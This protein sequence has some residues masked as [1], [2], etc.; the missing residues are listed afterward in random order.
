VAHGYGL[1]AAV[2]PAPY[3]AFVSLLLFAGVFA[4]GAWL[5]TWFCVHR[6]DE[7]SWPLFI[8]PIVGVAA[9]A[10]VLYPLT[11]FGAIGPRTLS[12]LAVLL[13][14]LGAWAF[15]RTLMGIWREL[16]PRLS[17]VRGTIFLW[18]AAPYWMLALLALAALSPST[19]ADSLHYHLGVALNFLQGDG[20][21]P[22]TPEW[23]HS[24]LSGSGEALIAL[25]LSIGAEQFASLLQ[26]SGVFC[27]CGLLLGLGPTRTGF[28]STVALAFV[29]S[30]VLILLVCSDKPQA[31]PIA[32]T[33]AALAITA[34]PSN[35]KFERSASLRRFALVCLL[36]M[37]A[38]QMKLNFLMSG[39]IVGCLA[40]TLMIKGGQLIPAASIAVS[41]LLLIVLPPAIWKQQHF[42]GTVLD[43]LLM[44]FPG[45]WPGTAAFVRY[46]RSYR[47]S[48]LWFPLSL[49]VPASIGVVSTIIGL[50]TFAPAWLR[51]AGDKRCW[52]VLAAASAVA[53]LGTLLGQASARF[54]LEPFAWVLMALVMQKTRPGR[55][56]A[57]IALTGVFLQTAVSAALFGYSVATSLPGALFDSARDRVMGKQADGYRMMRWVDGSLPAEAVLVS[58][59]ASI[60]LAPRKAFAS[61]WIHFTDARAEEWQPYLMRLKSG[62][63]THALVLGD[64]A[65]SPFAS[66]FSGTQAGPRNFSKATR[67]PLNVGAEYPAWLMKIDRE[68]LPGCFAK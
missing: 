25:G 40:M 8:S 51:P 5:A 67:N 58:E 7:S 2:L 1:E 55:I 10:A 32:M 30:P 31:V 66:C 11:L 3:A 20:A 62:G 19:N 41:G 13:A 47:D 29:S 34:Y 4:L 64:P 39:T 6:D 21:W 68:R 36:I 61:D 18:Q 12:V 60:G 57:A 54:Y 9:L 17:S 50:G 33:S 35:E 49:V 22:A 28:N 15:V 27:V 56:G 23:F 38:S 42:G 59:H 24:R 65:K 14:L 26:W 63:A 52:A 53:V 43:A 48:P 37:G 16:R 44:P 46:L 45:A